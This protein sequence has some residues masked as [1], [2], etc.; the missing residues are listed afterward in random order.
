MAR[1]WPLRGPTSGEVD[2]D[3]PNSTGRLMNQSPPD[4]AHRLGPREVNRGVTRPLDQSIPTA[5]QQRVRGSSPL[6]STHRGARCVC[7]QR[8]PPRFV[9]SRAAT[10]RV[11][12]RATRPWRG[13]VGYEAPSRALRVATMLASLLAGSLIGYA[14]VSLSRARLGSATVADGMIS[15]LVPRRTDWASS[16]T[17]G[18]TVGRH[19]HSFTHGSGSPPP[20]GQP[21]SQAAEPQH[22]RSTSSQSMLRRPHIPVRP[23]TEV[24]PRRRA[25]RTAPSGP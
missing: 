13:W 7:G 3:R 19:T 12:L 22:R 14:A 16:R 11:A 15:D 9:V 4:S 5:S 17:G 20:A 10:P 6:S 23:T 1:N 8:R 18:A 2:R 24:P 21:P 25:V